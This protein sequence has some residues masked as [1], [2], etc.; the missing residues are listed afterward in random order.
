M[1]SIDRGELGARLVERAYL[2]GDFVLRSGRRSSYYLDKYRFE[3]DP[4]LLDGLGRLIA[5]VLAEHAPDAE[6]LAGPELGA[7]PLAALASVHSGLPF[8]IVRKA[9]KDYGTAKRIEGVY[10]RGQRVCVV[11]DVVTSG[12]A[13]LDAVSGLRSAGMDVSAA[14]CVVDR[15]EGGAEAITAEGVRLESLYTV[16]DLGLTTAPDPV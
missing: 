7:V 2:T 15:L 10:E 13:L 1:N 3:T 5:E 12:G 9:A 14:I 4:V 8:V 6:L 11:E 16:A